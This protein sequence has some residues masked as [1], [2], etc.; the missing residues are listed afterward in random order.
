MWEFLGGVNESGGLVAL[1]GVAIM[2]A[3]GYAFRGLWKQNQALLAKIDELQ[4]KRVLDV[5]KIVRVLGENSEA[6][7]GVS[8]E[9]R[10]LVRLGD[11]RE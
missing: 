9:L 1:A 2:A 5:E 4:E 7:Q 6:M 8:S 3:I 10:L 11:R